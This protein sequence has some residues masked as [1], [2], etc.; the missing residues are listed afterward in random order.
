MRPPPP[1]NARRSL[2]LA[3]IRL[4]TVAAHIHSLRSMDRSAGSTP[5]A[6]LVLTCTCAVPLL[7]FALEMPL[8]LHHQALVQAASVL[9]CWRGVAPDVCSSEAVATPLSYVHSWASFTLQ[10]AIGSLPAAERYSAASSCRTTLLCVQL[11]LGLV[12][13]LWLT[14]LLESSLRRRHQSAAAAAAA[15]AA[16]VGG[17]QP[18]DGGPHLGTLL[19]VLASMAATWNVAQQLELSFAAA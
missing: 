14:H 9:M 8:A 17:A 1:C 11:Y 2:A 5:L 15:P 10:D 7:W 6:S 13:P 4:A 18:A 12:V 3:L 16:R 19:L